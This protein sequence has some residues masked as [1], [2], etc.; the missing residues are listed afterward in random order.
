MQPIFSRI[1][2]EFSQTLEPH[3]KGKSDCLMI[4]DFVV[5][6]LGSLEIETV[7][8]VAYFL[9][10]YTLAAFSQLPAFLST[11]GRASG[12]QEERASHVPLCLWALGTPTPCTA[13]EW[14]SIPE[15]SC[16]HLKPCDLE[17]V[18]PMAGHPANQGE[19]NKAKLQVKVF[20]L[21][22]CSWK[23]LWSRAFI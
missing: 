19:K 1:T 11:V 17:S 12:W 7:I 2:L 23:P 3:T 18:L 6:A 22:P 10:K 14:K 9:L 4:R 20:N 15:W 8:W 13:P 16:L 5:F 21:E